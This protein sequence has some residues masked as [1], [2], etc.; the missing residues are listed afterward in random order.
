[1]TKYVRRADAD[2]VA[3]ALKAALRGLGDELARAV[4]D[5]ITPEMTQ[6]EIQAVIAAE[7]VPMLRGVDQVKAEMD[8]QID[9]V[10]FEGDGDDV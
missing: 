4:A 1:M 9:A 7:I 3:S 6:A 2:R 8:A 10:A 5:L